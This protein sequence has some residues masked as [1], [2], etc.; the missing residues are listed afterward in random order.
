LPAGFARPIIV[1]AVVFYPWLYF[2]LIRLIG[3]S[4]LGLS[5]S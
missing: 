3:P 4:I 5:C 1:D 2:Y